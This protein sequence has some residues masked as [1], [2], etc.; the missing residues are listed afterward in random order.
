MAAC[1]HWDARQSAA[2]CLGRRVRI[3]RPPP[4]RR[5]D[6]HDRWRHRDFAA[7]ETKIRD[8]GPSMG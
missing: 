2:Y 1:P 7:S 6:R 3:T 4:L 5:G 8:S